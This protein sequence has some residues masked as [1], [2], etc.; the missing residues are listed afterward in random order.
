[1]PSPPKPRLGISA[2]LLGEPVRY[3]GG[4]KRD[5]FLVETFG[6]HVE[7]VPM[8]PEVEAGLGTPRETMR[9]MRVGRSP[10]ARGETYAGDRVALV[11]HKTGVD[12]TPVMRRYAERKVAAL[13]R[14]RLSGFVLKKDSP[15]CGMERVKVFSGEGPAE[16]A[17]RGV[18]AD[19]LVARFPFLPVEEEGRLSD[20]ML[21]D[22]FVERVFA[23]ERLQRLF[24]PR[25]SIDALVRF[26]TAHKL[27]LMAHSPSSYRSLGQLVAGARHRA[28]DA[29]RAEYTAAFMRALTALATPPRHA[30][31]LQHML[32]YFKKSLDTDARAELLDLIEAHRAGRVPLIVPITLFKHHVRRLGV[33]YLAEQV[34]LDPHPREMSLRNHV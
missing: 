8:C 20:P 7:W 16:R 24:D 14:E 17:G 19:A 9:L 2:C 26:H 18:F 13:E 29:V 11:I 1:M 5:S 21:R 33:V 4:H 12:V 23:Y 15:S 31:V 22:N 10:R 25:W 28:R 32:G 6:P 30:N 3:D 34:Y 27:T